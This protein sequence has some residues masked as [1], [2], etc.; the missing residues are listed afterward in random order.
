MD[1]VVLIDLLVKGNDSNA[2]MEATESV[3][4]V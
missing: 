4:A 2:E 1:C 3:T